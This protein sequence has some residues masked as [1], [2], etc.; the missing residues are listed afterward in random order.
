MEVNIDVG[1]AASKKENRRNKGGGC[2]IP[3]S[4]MEGIASS[5]SAAATHKIRVF[6][7][8]RAKK[9][10]SRIGFRPLNLLTERTQALCVSAQHGR[11]LQPWSQLYTSAL[12]SAP[13]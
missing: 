5:T 6:V 8:V 7:R 4:K 2:H 10:Q 3:S 12:G 9:T 11:A 13:S 1:I